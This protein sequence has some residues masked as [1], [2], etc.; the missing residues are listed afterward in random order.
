MLPNHNDH[1]CVRSI[2]SINLDQIVNFETRN[3]DLI[4]SDRHFID[5]HF[6]KVGTK[7]ELKWIFLFYRNSTL[8]L[9]RGSTA[10]RRTYGR[11]RVSAEHLHTMPIDAERDNWCHLILYEAK[12]DT[13]KWKVRKE[14]AWLTTFNWQQKF[15]S[16]QS[17]SFSTV[18]IE[19]FRQYFGYLL[20][21]P[22]IETFFRIFG[23]VPFPVTK[24]QV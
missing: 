24:F 4:K 9:M 7:K 5:L 12:V 14:F 19:F 8:Q 6:G 10:N 21:T 13:K 3:N 2:L 11:W 20:M 17:K 15:H 22:L 18:L 1:L 23:V 16:C